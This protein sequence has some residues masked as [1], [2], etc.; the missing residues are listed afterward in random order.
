M[1][2]RLSAGLLCLLMICS[3]CTD[4][5]PGIA[6]ATTTDTR[7]TATNAQ[8]INTNA[9]RGTEKSDNI[10]ISKTIAPADKENYFDITLTITDEETFAD[11]STDVVL[12]M[13]ISNTMNSNGR[14]G[15]AKSAAVSFL[16]QFAAATNKSDDCRV[17]L[18]TF[19]TNATIGFALTDA[20]IPTVTVFSTILFPKSPATAVPATVIPPQKRPRM[21]P[22]LS[23]KTVSAFIPSVLTLAVRPSSS[24]SR[25]NGIPAPSSSEPAKPM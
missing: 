9:D 16:N 5:L 11:N 8:Q 24:T 18:V 4:I 22:P 3:L 6:A 21:L 25:E 23:K 2:R 19:N 17:G 1:K 15:N 7:N 20:P 12:V 10:T 13:D 14:L